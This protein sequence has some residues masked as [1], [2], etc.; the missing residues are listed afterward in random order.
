MAPTISPAL[1]PVEEDELEE[2]EVLVAVGAAVVVDVA[3]ESDKQ[4]DT[5]LSWTNIDGD[6][7]P[8]ALEY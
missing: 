5:V 7:P 3:F 6:H 4:L 8:D 2:D 1:L